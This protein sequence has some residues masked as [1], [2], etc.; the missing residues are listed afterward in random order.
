VHRWKVI[1]GTNRSARRVDAH[2]LH[3]GGERAWLVADL[4]LKRGYMDRFVALRDARLEGNV[5]VVP[6]LLSFHV[7]E[8]VS[9]MEPFAAIQ[10]AAHAGPLKGLFILC[11]GAAGKNERL[12]ISMD[13]GGMGLVLGRQ[14]LVHTNVHQ[15]RRIRDIFE[16]IVVYSCG[17]ADTQP[18]NEGTR[19]DGRYLMGA[20]A[21]HTNATVYGSNL[22]QWYD[23]EPDDSYNFGEWEGT[24]L[25]FEP[26][27]YAPTSV[28]RA[29]VEF[30]DVLRGSCV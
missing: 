19:A 1:D 6:G 5:P 18:G 23:I 10:A 4:N 12:G 2:G 28:R 7:N 22:I 8:T 16:F 11:H 25:K 15:W 13:A 3:A 17:A 9:L 20:L 29:P 21:L 14:N 27:G 26:S 30:T 24:L